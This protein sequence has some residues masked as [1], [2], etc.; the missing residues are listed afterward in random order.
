MSRPKA[1]DSYTVT[2]HSPNGSSDPN[3]LWGQ[4]AEVKAT[5]VPARIR[6]HKTIWDELYR[7][8]TLRLEQTNNRHAL[9]VPFKDFKTVMRALTAIRHRFTRDHGAG[10]IT[11]SAQ[12]DPPVLYVQRG[13]T[14]SP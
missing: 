7:E 3:T 14:W 2:P 13:P 1:E 4:I 9:A 12:K 6:Y 11:L 8:L 10:S 5:D